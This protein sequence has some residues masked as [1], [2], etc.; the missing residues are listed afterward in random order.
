MLGIKTHRPLVVLWAHPRSSE[1]S[2]AKENMTYR[3]TAE[4][5]WQSTK[6]GWL[7]QHVMHCYYT[8]TRAKWIQNYVH[9]KFSRIYP[10]LFHLVTKDVLQTLMNSKANIPT[11]NIIPYLN[12][13]II[14]QPTIQNT[15]VIKEM[16]ETHGNK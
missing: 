5:V 9:K 12:T 16:G 7:R 4:S 10:E 14:I 6:A 8:A 11:A 2:T 15:T 1:Q 3:P 13:N